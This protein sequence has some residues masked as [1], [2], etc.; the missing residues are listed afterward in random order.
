MNRFYLSIICPCTPPP[1]LLS[2]SNCGYSAQGKAHH[3]TASTPPLQ[4]F[5]ESGTSSLPD[6][7]CCV[8]Q[9]CHFPLNQQ[10]TSIPPG[11]VCLNSLPTR[12]N[13][14]RRPRGLQETQYPLTLRP[15]TT[16]DCSTSF[17]AER[18]D[19]S[20]CARPR[21]TSKPVR[22]LPQRSQHETPRVR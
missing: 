2:G 6:L 15:R 1:R 10:H 4:H 22:T 8:H 7:W 18:T 19:H 17:R 3:R 12:L 20:S 14:L 16:L 13:G 5:P 11:P 9:A 21:S